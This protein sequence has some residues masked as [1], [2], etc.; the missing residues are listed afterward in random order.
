MG[1]GPELEGH[2]GCVELARARMA[3][4]VEKG[5]QT[6]MSW[7]A[8]RDQLG[9][10]PQDPHRRTPKGDLT[11]PVFVKFH[12]LDPGSDC[13]PIFWQGLSIPTYSLHFLISHTLILFRSLDILSQAR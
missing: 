8:E 6:V 2:R 9:I 12:Y 10:D 3:L 13:D 11:L 1:L 7:I 4:E 5:Y